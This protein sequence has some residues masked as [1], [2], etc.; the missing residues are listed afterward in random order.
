MKTPPPKETLAFRKPPPRCA[1]ANA[2]VSPKGKAEVSPERLTLAPRDGDCVAEER[3]AEKW[4]I[5]VVTI[6]IF[7]GVGTGGSVPA[8]R[9]VSGRGDEGVRTCEKG[10]DVLPGNRSR[11][12]AEER[13]GSWKWRW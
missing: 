1:Y 8:G 3:S 7:H 4:Y 5:G 6:A 13:E 9:L 12:P 11:C 2:L 10:P